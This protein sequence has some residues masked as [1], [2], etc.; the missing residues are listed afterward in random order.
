MQ[1]RR[2]QKLVDQRHLLLIFMMS[3]WLTGNKQVS[4]IKLTKLYQIFTRSI[5]RRLNKWRCLY[6]ESMMEPVTQRI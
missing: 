2:I 6:T 4:L 5:W 1:K 3:L